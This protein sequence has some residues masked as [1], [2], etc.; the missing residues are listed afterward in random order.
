MTNILS[1]T[2][3]LIGLLLTMSITACSSTSSDSRPLVDKLS[4][5][6]AAYSEAR[7]SDAETLYLSITE[8][9]PD[10]KEAWFKLGNIYARQGRLLA[11]I[12]CYQTVLSLDQQDGR[13][14]HNLALVK[15][16]QSRQIL[17]QAE[18]TL[19]ADSQQI[20]KIQKLR[21]KLNDVSKG[22]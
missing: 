3:F 18:Q 4:E 20:P 12:N 9:N 16:N 15:L 5:A 10:F 6:N 22:I 2:Q 19:A 13:A 17:R 8:S 14:W 11:A 7:L 21:K 1:L